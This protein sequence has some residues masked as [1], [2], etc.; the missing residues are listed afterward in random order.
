MTALYWL[1]SSFIGQLL[2]FST[3]NLSSPLQN[4]LNHYC[5]IRSLAVPRPNALVMLQAVSAALQPMLNLNKKN[6]SNL[7]SVLISFP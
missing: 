1:L 4:F 5:T 6:H 2:C 3:S 7:L